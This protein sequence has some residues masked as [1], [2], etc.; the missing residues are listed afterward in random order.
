MPPLWG[1]RCGTIP[2][3]QTMIQKL[4]L[5]HPTACSI[6][7][8][9]VC[10]CRGQTASCRRPGL[11]CQPL[12][13]GKFWSGWHLPI[14]LSTGYVGVLCAGKALRQEHVCIIDCALNP[15]GDFPAKSRVRRGDTQK[16]DPITY[17]DDLSS[18]LRIEKFNLTPCFL[19]AQSSARYKRNGSNG[20]AK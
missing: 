11:F 17:R 5:K 20:L 19:L 8:T 14:K 16:S 7:T 2:S 3:T 1:T 15:V 4:K 6:C 18:F 13:P 12:L 10:C 9:A